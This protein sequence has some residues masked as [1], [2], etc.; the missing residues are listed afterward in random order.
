M[1]ANCI[2]R[3]EFGSTGISLSIVGFG[4]IVIKGAKQEHANSVVARAVEL[5]VN[6]FDV[7]PQYGNAQE[8][9]GPALEPHREDV[10]LACKTLKRDADGARSDLE[11]SLNL[12]RT[13][14]FDLYQ[15][16]NLADV[17]KDVDAAFAK[18]GAME[19]LIEA[20][21]QGRLRHLGFSAHSVDAALAAMD[22]HD[23]DSV[24]FPV[25]FATFT[26]GNFGP[27][28]MEKAQARGMARLA[29]K[30][31]ASQKWPE[32][33][34]ERQTYGKCW[35]KPV[36]DKRVAELAFRFTLSQPVTA[37]ITPGEEKFLW[38][39]IAFAERFQPIG[40]DEISDL[41]KIAE[42]LSLIFSYQDVG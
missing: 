5:G 18:G 40:P 13:D 35:Y 16:H 14:Y 31:L 2:P 4:G 26:R 32:N 20:K 27:Q 17:G 41:Q 10:F 19:V 29:L 11:N 6:Y 3:R 7:A 28:I 30:S 36:T 24:L 22:R 21:Q 38:W 9:L 25:N 15:L 1:S 33:D 42:S 8:I 12:L 34:P 37:A 23:F 39:M